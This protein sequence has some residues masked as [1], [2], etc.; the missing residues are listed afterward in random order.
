MHLPLWASRIHLAWDRVADLGSAGSSIRFDSGHQPISSGENHMQTTKRNVAGLAIA[1][2]A[3]TL[4]A[5]APVT[6]SA[7]GTPGHCAG[8]NACKGT[9]SC[10]TANSACKGHNECKGKGFVIV[11]EETCGQLGG[12]FSAG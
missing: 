6:V 5:V 7:G 12:T 10:K 3:A 9:S 8:V 11:D 1:A 4:F 2:A